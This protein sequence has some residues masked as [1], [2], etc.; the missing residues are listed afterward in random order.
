MTK[1]IKIEELIPYIPYNKGY[2][3]C[4]WYG[5]WLFFYDKPHIVGND[6]Y[7]GDEEGEILSDIIN[8]APAEDWENSLIK[9]GGK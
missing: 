3:V 1:Q 2:V 8:I 5:V 6:W 4:D 7:A 9:I